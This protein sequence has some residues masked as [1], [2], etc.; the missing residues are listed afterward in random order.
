MVF[1][2]VVFLQFMLQ[3]YVF[4]QAFIPERTFCA[5]ET[6]TFEEHDDFMYIYIACEPYRKIRCTQI[7]LPPFSQTLYPLAPPK[8]RKLPAAKALPVIRRLV[9]LISKRTAGAFSGGR[10]CQYILRIKERSL[11]RGGRRVLRDQ[12][13]G[14]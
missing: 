5:W 11:R 14:G 12:R 8:L 2:I 9:N 7:P 6:S 10:F 3:H 1:D 13:V 4:Y